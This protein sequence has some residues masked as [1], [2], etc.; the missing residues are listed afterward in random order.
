MLA[1]TNPC[2]VAVIGEAT[3]LPNKVKPLQHNPETIISN[4]PRIEGWEALGNISNTKP[5][6]ATA[7]PIISTKESLC[8]LNL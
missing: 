5:P 6:N 3:F 4:A 7:I 1:T 8:P 2:R